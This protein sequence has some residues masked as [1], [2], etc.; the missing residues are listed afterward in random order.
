MGAARL[1]NFNNELGS[2]R[3]VIT[4]IAGTEDQKRLNGVNS[5][6]DRG[7]AILNMM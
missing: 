1:T 7:R 6:T 3:T 4:W 2:T 5:K